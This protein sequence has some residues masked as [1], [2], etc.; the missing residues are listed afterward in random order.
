[1]ITL[2]EFLSI[3]KGVGLNND[4]LR[5]FYYSVNKTV[6]LRLVGKR[7]W[8]EIFKI[9]EQCQ[10]PIFKEIDDPKLPIYEGADRGLLGRF[11]ETIHAEKSLRDRKEHMDKLRYWTRLRVVIDERI[12]L[13]TQIFG[14]SDEDIRH[15]EMVAARYSK[16]VDGRIAR[17]KKLWTIGIGTGAATL[18]GVAAWYL[19]KKDKK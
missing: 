7:L 13:F 10:W 18:A 12:E 8:S 6:I 17:R 4:S 11:I 1:M 3:F 5:I 15:C 14:F 2:D 16:M 19:Y 9:E